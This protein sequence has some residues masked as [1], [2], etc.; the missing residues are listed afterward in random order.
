MRKSD[1]GQ[2]TGEAHCDVIEALTHRCFHK[3]EEEEAATEPVMFLITGY[4]AASRGIEMIIVIAPRRSG[5]TVSRKHFELPG[6]ADW[7]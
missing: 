3:N 6:V 2:Q 4:V 1:A 5:R 7:C